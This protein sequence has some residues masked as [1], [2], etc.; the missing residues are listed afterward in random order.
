MYWPI[1]APRIYAASK[2][3]LGRNNDE[4]DE[5]NAIPVEISVANENNP[6]KERLAP[7]SNPNREDASEPVASKPRKGPR[8]PTLL[9]STSMGGAQENRVGD[10]IVGMKLSRSG[11]LFATITSSTLSIWQTKV[12]MSD[13]IIFHNLT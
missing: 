5:N 8:Y 3:N 13:D 6:Q 11:H 7:E 1:G 2:F 12:S 4:I 10:E 9:K